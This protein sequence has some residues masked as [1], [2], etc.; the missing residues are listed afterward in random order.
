M[1]C[2]N[3]LTQPQTVEYARKLLVEKLDNE[4][5]A[6]MENAVARFPKDPEIRIFY[7]SSLLPFRPEDVPWQVATAIQLEPDNPWRLTRAASMLFGL[8]EVEAARSYAGHAARLAPEGFEFAPEL[9]SLGGVLAAMEGED[10]LAEELFRGALE[11]EPNRPDFALDFARF[12][13]D[14]NRAEEALAIIDSALA[15]AP[16]HAKLNS[17]RDDLSNAE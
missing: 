4:L 17:L 15:V 14:R 3:D 1:T 12:L 7:A 11:E 5:V 10:V 16:H 8:G 13:A 6:F 2:Y 9:A